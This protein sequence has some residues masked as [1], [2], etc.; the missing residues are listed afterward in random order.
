VE[1]SP[2]LIMNEI[3]HDY[4]TNRV[5][6]RPSSAG[7]ESALNQKLTKDSHKLINHA[8]VKIAEQLQGIL[9]KATAPQEKADILSNWFGFLKTG[10]R[11]I[12]VTVEDEA[13]AY[14]MFE[15]L[16]DRGLELS[17]AD[18]LKNFLLSRSGHR[19]N[20]VLQGWISMQTFL[21]ASGKEEDNLLVTYIRHFWS[22]HHALTRERELYASIKDDIKDSEVKAFN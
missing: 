20:E 1:L 19:V 2:K 14:V 7:R 10:T 3:D 16:N 9:K 11:V 22:A 8:A 17:K 5:I 13:K 12:W 21:E 18:L 6:A 4:F 15:T